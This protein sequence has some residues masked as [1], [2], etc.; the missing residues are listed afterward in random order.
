MYKE[1][2]INDSYIA[3][4]ILFNLWLLFCDKTKINN[5]YK[6]INAF[7]GKIKRVFNIEDNNKQQLFNDNR[8]RGFE[9][10]YFI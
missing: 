4:I 10:S 8:F 6:N 5:Q 2:Y 9:L 1:I 3:T 7:S